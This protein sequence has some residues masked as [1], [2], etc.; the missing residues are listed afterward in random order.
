[1]ITW[2][3]LHSWSAPAACH[4]TS[5]QIQHARALL[6]RPDATIASV[7]RPLNVS[8]STLYKYVPELKEGRR[9][10]LEAPAVPTARAELPSG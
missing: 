4:E 3:R 10:V 2:S 8:R 5:E 1:M 9:P 6:A 7:A